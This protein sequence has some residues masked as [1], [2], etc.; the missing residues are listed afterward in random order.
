MPRMQQIDRHYRE[1]NLF[2]TTNFVQKAG[3]SRQKE[4]IFDTW[5][6]YHLGELHCK[7]AC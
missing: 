4:V 3:I 6:L 1:F 2:L 7:N 5:L